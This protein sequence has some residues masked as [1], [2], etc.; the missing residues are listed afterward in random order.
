MAIVNEPG[1][2]ATKEAERARLR[3]LLRGITSSARE[4]WSNRIVGHLRSWLPSHPLRIALFSALPDEPDLSS[5]W[6]LAPNHRWCVP[7]VRGSEL[8]FHTATAP[9]QLR[10]GSF[11]I[12]E[13]DPQLHPMIAIGNLDLLLCPGLGFT[14][15]GTRLGRGKGYYDRALAESRPDACRIGVLFACQRCESLPVEEHDQHMTHLVDENG[16]HPVP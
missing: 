3:R 1:D 13:P 10:A 9:S 7:L 2:P 5:L 12:R 14:S 8:T 11:G 15:A 16:I 6:E 4:E